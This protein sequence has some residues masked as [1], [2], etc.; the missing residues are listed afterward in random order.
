MP[1]LVY[2]LLVLSV[3]SDLSYSEAASAAQCRDAAGKFVK[4]PKVTHCRND[5]GRYVKCG[6]PGARPA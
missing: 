5:A 6:T 3:G 2:L 4:C 1:W